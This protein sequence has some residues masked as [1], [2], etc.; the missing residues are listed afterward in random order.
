MSDKIK[1]YIEF[2]GSVYKPD[3]WTDEQYDEFVDKM[4]ELAESFGDSVQLACT[5]A[6]K[7]EEEME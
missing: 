7:S 6:K 5:Y 3:S 1:Q 2:S 4:V